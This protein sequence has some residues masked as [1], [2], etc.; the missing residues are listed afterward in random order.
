MTPAEKWETVLRLV[1]GD[2]TTNDMENIS[3]YNFN[4]GQT[5]PTEEEVEANFNAHEYIQKR[6]AEYPSLQDQ[7]DMLYWDRTNGTKTWEESIDKVK[8]DNPKPE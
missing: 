1:G 8:A 3:S 6:E 4:D 7:L 2:I 5:P